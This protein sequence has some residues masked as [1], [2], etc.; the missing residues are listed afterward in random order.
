MRVNE[1]LQRV[2]KTARAELPPRWRGFDARAHFTFAQISYGKRSV[3]YEVWVRG[4]AHLLEIGL[5]FESDRATNAAWL[6][7]FAARAFEIKAELGE[8]VEIE[9]W[10]ASWTRVHQVMPYEKLDESTAHAAA[11][12][13]AKMIVILQPMLEQRTEK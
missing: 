5:H 11:E 13:L 3:H 12:H 9:Q 2:V 8:T 10:T 7:Y 4:A 6:D 1:F